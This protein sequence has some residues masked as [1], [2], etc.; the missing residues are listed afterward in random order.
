MPADRYSVELDLEAL[1]C[2][3]P[4]FAKVALYRCAQECISNMLRHARANRFTLA[5]RVSG[6]EIGL[7]VC[8]NGCGFSPAKDVSEG[9]GIAS[10]HEYACMAGGVCQISS[11]SAGT[12]ILIRIPL[13]HE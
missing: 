10:L 13:V 5:L 12:T 4:H 8:D 9:I 6:A 11:G 7:E 3:P 2:D 1:A